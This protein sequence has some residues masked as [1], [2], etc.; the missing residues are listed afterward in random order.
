MGNPRHVGR[1]D[2]PLG[3]FQVEV[4]PAEAEVSP[5]LVTI[6]IGVHLSWA[7]TMRLLS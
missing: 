3:D 5:Q 4:V 7:K 2:E 1:V 6:G